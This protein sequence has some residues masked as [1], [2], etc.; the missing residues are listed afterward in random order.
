MK[1]YKDKTFNYWA[2]IIINNS[3]AIINYKSEIRF[4][5]NGLAHNSKNAA[6]SYGFYK[7]FFLNGKNY[8]DQYE[9]TKESWRKFVKLQVFL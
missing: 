3:N 4:F 9:F 1:F 7:R 6:V 8:G 2:F 5:K